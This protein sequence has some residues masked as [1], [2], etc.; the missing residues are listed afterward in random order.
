[1]K[2]SKKKMARW[3]RAVLTVAAVI[4]AIAA[5]AGTVVCIV[6]HDEIATLA[7]ISQ[8]RARNDAHKDG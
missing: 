5:A 8:V 3:K 7:S 4:L 2:K 1:M 6:W